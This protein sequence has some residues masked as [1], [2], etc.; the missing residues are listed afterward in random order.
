MALDCYT[1]FRLKGRLNIQAAAGPARRKRI[2]KWAAPA[3]KTGW[4]LQAS[5]RPAF[6]SAALQQKHAGAL[7]RQGRA[8]VLL[9]HT[10]RLDGFSTGAGRLERPAVSRLHF[11]P[12]VSSRY[13][14][15]TVPLPLSEEWE[16]LRSRSGLRV[17][18]KATAVSKS[19]SQ[20]VT[21]EA[22]KTLNATF[23]FI[24]S[25]ITVCSIAL[26]RRPSARM[27]R[28]ALPNI[29]SDQMEGMPGT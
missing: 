10:S 19:L 18:A 20:G 25:V 13:H 23:G 12:S 6:K 29:A 5:R 17:L 26:P 2:P 11:R 21:P 24:G 22:R 4:G 1:G 9:E 28:G 7:Q 8:F 27:T 3:R 16:M 15:T 14:T